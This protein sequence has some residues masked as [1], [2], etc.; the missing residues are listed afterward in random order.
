MKKNILYLSIV[1]FFT[2]NIILYFFYIEGKQKINSGKLINR[3]TTNFFDY[4][5]FQID[6][7]EKLEKEVEIF[8]DDKCIYKNGV[9]RKGIKN[10]YGWNCFHVYLKGYEKFIICHYKKNNWHTN[11]YKLKITN[12]F[13]DVDMKLEIN[14]PDSLENLFYKKI[15]SNKNKKII[16]FLDNQKLLYKIDT[17]NNIIK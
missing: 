11:D 1:I 10:K 8:F 6:S 5:T 4:N 17:L 15:M 12:D 13:N 7:N 9:S 16:Y 3:I 14:G 2:S